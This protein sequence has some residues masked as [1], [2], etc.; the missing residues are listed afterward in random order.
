MKIEFSC[1]QRTN[2]QP[3][4]FTMKIYKILTNLALFININLSFNH[5]LK[6]KERESAY[7]FLIKKMDRLRTF[8]QKKRERERK[9]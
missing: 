1:L 8:N 5:Y 6:A 3:E 9:T 4:N 7:R 2:V